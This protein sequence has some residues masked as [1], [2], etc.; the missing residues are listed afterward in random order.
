MFIGMNCDYTG[1]LAKGFPCYSNANIL[2]DRMQYK[3]TGCGPMTTGD[4][5]GLS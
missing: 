5:N 3:S 2:Y 4:L 1:Q